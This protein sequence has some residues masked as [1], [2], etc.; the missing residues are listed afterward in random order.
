MG[1]E[2]LDLYRANFLQTMHGD[3]LGLS[4]FY[5]FQGEVSVIFLHRL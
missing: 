5:V 3:M 4:V 1:I 2:L